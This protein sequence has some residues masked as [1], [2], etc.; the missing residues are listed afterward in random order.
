[1]TVG[2]AACTPSARP[3]SDTEKHLKTLAILYG[4]FMN[5]HRGQA[6]ANEG[7]LKKFIQSLSPEQLDAMGV[8]ASNLDSLFVSPR[9][10]LPYGVAWKPASAKAS[11]PAGMPGMPPGAGADKAVVTMVVWEQKGAG[12]KHFVADSLGKVEEIDDATFQKRLSE[13]PSSK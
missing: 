2:L 10:S 5:T 7:E 1:M 4:R 8:N 13:V 12:G 6:P 11:G 3:P 9:D